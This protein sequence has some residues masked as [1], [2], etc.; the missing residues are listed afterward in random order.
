MTMVRPP[1]WR[2]WMPSA[3]CWQPDNSWCRPAAHCCPA[4][5]ACIWRWVVDRCHQLL[6]NRQ[7]A[8]LVLFSLG[9]A[10]SSKSVF[11]HSKLGWIIL[12]VL[13]LSGS[14]LA[15]QQL[16]AGGAGA[17]LVSG[18]GRIEATEFDISTK[19]PGRIEQI[20]VAEGEFVKAGQV[21]VRMQSDSLL[22]QRDE[23]E[24]ALHQAHTAV[25]AA[26]A[27]LALRGSDE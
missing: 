2:C 21:L 12:A 4:R 13:V 23:A 24:A 15:W 18:N 17:G 1:I 20:L 14:Y 26:Q 16:S 3:I 7:M 19:L 8:V 9:V 22:A 27:Q 5:L 6:P 25:A 11:R 10:M